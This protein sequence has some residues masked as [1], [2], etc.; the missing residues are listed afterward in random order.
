MREKDVRLLD[1]PQPHVLVFRDEFH[2]QHPLDAPRE[3]VG[4]SENLLRRKPV[5]NIEDLPLVPVLFEYERRKS[6][7]SLLREGSHL[8]LDALEFIAALQHR[9]D[10]GKTAEHPRIAPVVEEAHVRREEIGRDDGESFLREKNE[11]RLVAER[12]GKRASHENEERSLRRAERLD[13]RLVIFA[14]ERL[15]DI[16]RPDKEIDS[17]EEGIVGRNPLD[18]LRRR[19]N[20]D[21][22]RNGMPQEEFLHAAEIGKL[23][24]FREISVLKRLRQNPRID[25]EPGSG[26]PVHAEDGLI[27]AEILGN[28]A[29][30]PEIQ[31]GSRQNESQDSLD[32]GRDN[33]HGGIMVNEKLRGKPE[34][35]AEVRHEND[36]RKAAQRERNIG[37]APDGDDEQR[38]DKRKRAYD[39]RGID[40][41]VLDE[42]NTDSRY[43]KQ[44]QHKALPQKQIEHADNDTGI[45]ASTP[46]CAK[47]RFR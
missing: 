11:I 14:L 17:V 27:D 3:F 18:F 28:A 39:R 47:Q 38:H 9:A 41:R 44:Q 5:R 40:F 32:Y 1:E 34:N 45:R 21:G 23:R 29:H 26:V 8:A 13:R 20:R 10:D 30:R 4:E 6:L 35:S 19:I 7:V 2:L 24:D 31:H 46:P 25:A 36:E 42:E 33:E 12:L 22:P 15:D 16:V 43:K 37:K